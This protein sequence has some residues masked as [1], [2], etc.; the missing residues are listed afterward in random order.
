MKD[1]ALYLITVGKDRDNITPKLHS[2]VMR[3]SRVNILRKLKRDIS[4]TIF[5]TNNINIYNNIN[6]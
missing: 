3:I 2:C 1:C 4:I 5:I 6:I